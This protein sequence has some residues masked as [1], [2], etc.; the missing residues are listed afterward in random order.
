[1]HTIPIIGEAKLRFSIANQMSWQLY[2]NFSLRI[3]P[4]KLKKN[5]NKTKASSA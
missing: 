5:K 2:V 3:S 1:M 4:S